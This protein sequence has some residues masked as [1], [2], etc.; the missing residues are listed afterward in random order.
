MASNENRVLQ[1]VGHYLTL[2]KHFFW[3]NNTIP[4]PI[5]NNGKLAFRRM[6]KFSMNGTPDFILIKDGFFIGLEV[7]DK[8]TQSKEQ[9]IFQAKCKENGA[10][11][12]LIRSITDLQ[13]VGL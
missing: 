5:H 13:N 2:K 9:K 7:K 10:E 8:G 4:P 11:Y 12:Y 3:R 6:P 1:A